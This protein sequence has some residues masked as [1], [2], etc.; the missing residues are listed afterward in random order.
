MFE[1]LNIVCNLVN[2]FEKKRSRRDFV[3]SKQQANIAGKRSLHTGIKRPLMA[4]A[5]AVHEL[6]VAFFSIYLCHLRHLY[7]FDTTILLTLGLDMSKSFES[8]CEKP[9]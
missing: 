7:V 5:D 1:K 6:F 4:T 9:L 3:E 8:S 2:S